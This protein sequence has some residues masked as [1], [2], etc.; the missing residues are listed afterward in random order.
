MRVVHIADDAEVYCR[1]GGVDAALTMLKARAGTEFDPELVELCCAKSDEIFG[2]L[3]SVD[4]WNVVLDGC[5]PLDR[6]IPDSDLTQVL[7]TFADYADL[8]SPWFLGHSQG[9]AELARDAAAHLG[10][11]A[12]EVA[13]VQ[14]SALVYRLGTIGVSSGIWD[15]PGPL[16]R[17]EW[18]RV[19]TVPYL[20]ER[21]LCRQRRL[22][23]IGAIAAMCHER[24][25]GS[26]YPRGLP[27]GAIPP[28]AR[29][30]AAADVY[31]ALAA[32]RPHRAALSRADRAE[33]L[34][35]EVAAG[36][37]DAAMVRAVL[38]AAGHPVKKRAP[39]V[40]GLTAREAEI[41]ELVVRGRSH[42]QIAAELM[43]STRTVGSHVEHIYTKIGVTTRGAA[44]MYA[45]RHGLV[46]LRV[47]S[48]EATENIG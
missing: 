10:M 34:H 23:E 47:S 21:V 46:D 14:R 1:A 12:A 7:G 48:A 29:L 26:G 30:L 5:A 24:M 15:K 20:T 36:R 35:S 33:A 2:D 41:L 6:V 13:L 27:G 44:A 43:I 38:G 4:A 22:A 3:G 9:V 32:G 16:S 37:L 17:I 11:S 18:E 40:A 19:R 31:Q 39:R 42:R 8:K 28:P 25:D 45:M